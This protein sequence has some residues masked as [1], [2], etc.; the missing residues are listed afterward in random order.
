VTELPTA[1]LFAYATQLGAAP[2]ALE[3]VSDDTA[4]LVFASAAAARAGLAK[5]RRDGPDDGD[6]WPARAVPARCGR[7]QPA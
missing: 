1:R 4:V 5:L 6:G 2:L 7:P 3:W